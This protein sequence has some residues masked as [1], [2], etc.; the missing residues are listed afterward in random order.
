MK[1]GNRTLIRDAL[2]IF[3]AHVGAT[4]VTLLLNMALAQFMIGYSLLWVIPLSL[5]AYALTIYTCT[6]QIGHADRNSALYEH[7]LLDK[8]RGLK[9][10]LIANSLNFLSALILL[11]NYILYRT[12]LLTHLS[13]VIPYKIINAAVWPIMNAIQ[14]SAFLGDFNFGSML[15]CCLLPFLMA[16]I[17]E[18]I[19][20]LGLHDISLV[21]K[22]V[23]KNKKKNPGKS[24]ATQKP[25]PS[26]RSWANQSQPEETEKKP[27]L[28]H[29][30]LYTQE[31]NT[32]K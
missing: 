18:P 16:L 26:N 19:Y 2:S 13:F 5:L 32:K 12:E 4:V 10:G 1:T 7:S 31:D 20:L 28:L 6:W 21:E 25:N 17:C 30:I 3:A 27:S 14:V 15:L 24:N 22:A 11:V 9:L 29:R 8:T 23:Y